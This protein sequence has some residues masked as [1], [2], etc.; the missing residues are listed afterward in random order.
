MITSHL[1]WN[2]ECTM[3]VEFVAAMA[4]VSNLGSDVFRAKG[5]D[6]AALHRAVLQL[7]R[8]AWRV[9]HKKKL[10]M[11]DEQSRVFAKA[12]L[13]EVIKP[14]CRVC[15]GAGVS[16]IDELKVICPACDGVAIHRYGDK[17]RARLCGI[18]P[19][20]WHLWESRYWLVLAIAR[21]H[22]RAPKEAEDRLG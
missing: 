15:T 21:N 22:D 20:K 14:H 19:D 13:I 16:I 11:S 7:A 12:V 8:K 17:E 4:G 6:R 10:P 1:E 5:Y 3:P 9:G 2:D 18:R